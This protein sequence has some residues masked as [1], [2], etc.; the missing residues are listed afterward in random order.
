VC[1]ITG[2]ATFV[3]FILPVVKRL[4]GT[5]HRTFWWSRGHELGSTRADQAF[6]H[7]TP[8]GELAGG[9]GSGMRPIVSACYFAVTLSYNKHWRLSFR[10]VSE[11]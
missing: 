2:F 9:N 8:Q 7:S 6:R 3:F 5:L 1:I 4:E 11:G 10:K